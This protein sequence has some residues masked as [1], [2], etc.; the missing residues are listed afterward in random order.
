MITTPC[1]YSAQDFD[2]RIP[3]TAEDVC[4][5]KQET[6]LAKIVER[7]ALQHSKIA[8]SSLHCICG[9]DALRQ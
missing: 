4:R 5:G 2:D 7:D 3:I 8:Q 1:V 6:V 9:C